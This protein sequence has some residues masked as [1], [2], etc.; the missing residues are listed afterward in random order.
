MSSWNASSSSASTSIPL[1]AACALTIAVSASTAVLP[2]A[3]ETGVPFGVPPGGSWAVCQ[4]TPL[5]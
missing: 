4:A 2:A 1:A 3:I 5:T